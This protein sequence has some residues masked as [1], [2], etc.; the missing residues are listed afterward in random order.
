[1]LRPNGTPT[2]AVS[3]DDSTFTSGNVGFYSWGNSGSQ[4]R[5]LKFKP[6]K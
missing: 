2:L 6:A 4:F 3:V 5:N 1:M